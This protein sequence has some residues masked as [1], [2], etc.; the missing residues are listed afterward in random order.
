MPLK[1]IPSIISPDLLRALAL[2]GHGDEILLADCYF[3]ATA[4]SFI[5]ESKPILIRADGHNIPELLEAI[6]HLINLDTYVQYPVTL[7]DRVKQDKEKD[8]EVPIWD[9]Y[10][11]ILG[12]SDAAPTSGE[13]SFLER[14][15]FYE[16]VKKVFVIVQTG[17][18]AQYGNIILTNGLVLPRPILCN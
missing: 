11:R 5:A 3:P 9:T 13:T 8:L 2:M 15:Q 14:F 18:T 10:A 1:G 4:I 6:L 12:K 17:E 7:M 16:R